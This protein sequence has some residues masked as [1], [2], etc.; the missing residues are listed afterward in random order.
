MTYFLHW[1]LFTFLLTYDIHFNWFPVDFYGFF[2]LKIEQIRHVLGCYYFQKPFKKSII[3]VFS[4]CHLGILP[5]L[6]RTMFCCLFVRF[7]YFFKYKVLLPPWQLLAPGP[8][9]THVKTNYQIIMA[10]SVRLRRMSLNYV[11]FFL[12]KKYCCANPYSGKKGS[13]SHHG[14][15]RLFFFFFFFLLQNIRYWPVKNVCLFC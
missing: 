14:K 12:K 10:L 5:S 6:I 3:L 4:C 11:Y 2:E 7:D 8:Y 1:I 9:K 15:G 13:A